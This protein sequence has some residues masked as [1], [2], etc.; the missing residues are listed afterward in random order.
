MTPVRFLE[1]G[2]KFMFYYPWFAHKCFQVT[3]IFLFKAPIVKAIFPWHGRSN[4]MWKRRFSVIMTLLRR[5]CAG[6]RWFGRKWKPIL[7]K[8]TYARSPLLS[9]APTATCHSSLLWNEIIQSVISNAAEFHA[10]FAPIWLILVTRCHVQLILMHNMLMFSFCHYQAGY[11]FI[12]MKSLCDLMVNTLRP[13][14]DRCVGK[15]LPW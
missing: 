1:P 12:C 15:C 8:W 13:E 6:M 10:P 3:A 4:V 14:Q 11:L 7:Y 2:I 5:V 9:T